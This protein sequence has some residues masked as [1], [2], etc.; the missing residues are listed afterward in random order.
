MVNLAHV[1]T[2]FLTLFTYLKNT[3]RKNQITPREKIKK[4]SFSTQQLPKIFTNPPSKRQK[5]F[6][7]LKARERFKNSTKI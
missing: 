6:I 1:L 3:K 2:Y 5:V 7:G 4:Y